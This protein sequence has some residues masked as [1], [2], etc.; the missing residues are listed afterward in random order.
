MF[1]SGCIVRGFDSTRPGSFSC[2][3]GHVASW[4]GVWV[5]WIWHRIMG[6]GASFPWFGEC[7]GAWLGWGAVA[8]C[9]IRMRAESV[10]LLSGFCFMYVNMWIV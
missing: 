4:L 6:S 8:G 7:I 1:A 3:W 2:G 9:G 5:W 10:L